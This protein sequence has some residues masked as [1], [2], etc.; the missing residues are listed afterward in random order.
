MVKLRSKKKQIRN[1]RP[2]K[3][4]NKFIVH[5]VLAAFLLFLSILFLIFVF[6]PIKTVTYNVKFIIGEHIGFDLN[7]SDLVF[8]Q[9]IQDSSAT[10]S[11]RIENTYAFPII[12]K[13]FASKEVI[14]FLRV[15]SVVV[16]P[17]ETVLLPATINAPKNIS[18]GEYSGV[19]KFKV[20]KYNAK[21]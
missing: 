3:S 20:Y 11:L 10:R 16:Q 5:L 13:P 19:L 12:L 17:G 14:S 15:D 21:N 7:S 2:G 1:K 9:L 8:G 4:D 6:S 18:F